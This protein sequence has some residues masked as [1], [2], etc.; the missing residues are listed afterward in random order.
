[1]KWKASVSDKKYVTWN[2][3]KGNS[4][5]LLKREEAMNVQAC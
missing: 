5:C 3:E 1:M 4:G 2:S